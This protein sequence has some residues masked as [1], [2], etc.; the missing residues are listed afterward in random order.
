MKNSTTTYSLL[1]ITSITLLACYSTTLPSLATATPQNIITVPPMPTEFLTQP[2]T[3]ATQ[4]G[5]GSSLENENLLVEV[6]QGFKIDYQA[7]QN[8]IVINEMV[9][10]SESVND[11]TTLVTV[12]IFL[13]M[14][15]TTPEQYQDS[16]TQSWFNACSDSESYPVADGTENGYDFVL[17][18]LHCPINLST[19]KVEYTYLKAIQGNDSFYLVQVAFRHEPSPDEITQWMNYLRTVQVCDSR[20]PEQACP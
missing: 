7:E 18:Q 19:Q 11:W 15:N 13:G 3:V 17:W 12:Q 6:P 16:L 20:I 9:P 2:Q 5:S 14:T 1:I 4:T 10:Q 8:N